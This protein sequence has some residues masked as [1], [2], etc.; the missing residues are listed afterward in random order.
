MPYISAAA[1]IDPLFA[2]L[3]HP[4]PSSIPPFYNLIQQNAILPYHTDFPW[5][6]PIPQQSFQR[7]PQAGPSQYPT[8]AMSELQFR[9]HSNITQG[10]TD[11]QSPPPGAS[12]ATGHPP[13]PPE[14]ELEAAEE[15][16]HRNTAASGKTL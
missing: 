2:E 5:N 8:M 4:G 13:I 1:A 15:K 12:D 14:V 3:S 16:R 7:L 9:G 10:A 6:P 11:P